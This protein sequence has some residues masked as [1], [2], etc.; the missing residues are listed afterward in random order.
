[1]VG[2]AH[3]TFLLLWSEIMPSQFSQA[4]QELPHLGRAFQPISGGGGR[5]GVSHLDG[6][7]LLTQHREDG[8]VGVVIV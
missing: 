1:M 8:F 5:P 4:G 6:Q 3:P 2:G 7:A